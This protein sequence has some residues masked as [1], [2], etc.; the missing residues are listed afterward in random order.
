MYNVITMSPISQIRHRHDSNTTFI[1]DAV[2]MP[3]MQI[4]LNLHDA[5]TTPIVCWEGVFSEQKK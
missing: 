3:P 1:H 4:N 2:T 5:I